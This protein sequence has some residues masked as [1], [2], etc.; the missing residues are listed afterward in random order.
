[1]FKSNLLHRQI[2]KSPFCIAIYFSVFLYRLE[3]ILTHRKPSILEA[4]SG[5]A[6]GIV[7]IISLASP[8]IRQPRSSLI[9]IPNPSGYALSLTTQ[10]ECFVVFYRR[11]RLLIE[12]RD[13]RFE[14]VSA[15][16]RSILHQYEELKQRYG[17][18][19]EDRKVCGNELNTRSVEFLDDLHQ[20]HDAATQYFVGLSMRF[21]ADNEKR[22][23]FSYKELMYSHIRHA[24]NYFPDAMERIDES[25]ARDQYG[26]RAVPWRIEGAHVYFDNIE[27]IAGDMR[28]YGFD[29]P[30]VVEEAW[31]TMMWKGFLWHRCHHMVEGPRVPSSN[32]G[33]QLPVYIG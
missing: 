3:Q 22:Q 21:S 24:V 1:M 9:R 14:T 17:D 23:G 29:M 28:D 15:Q 8:M 4:Y 2:L 20:R 19:W 6:P 30:E 16:T 11:L 32:W 27:K 5:Q 31:L 25:R 13:A 33:S 18:R 26:L 7:D 12:E 10:T